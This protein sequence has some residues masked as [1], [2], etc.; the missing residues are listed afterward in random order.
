MKSS[1]K[2]YLFYA[3]L[4]IV[5]GSLLYILVETVRAKNT[6]FE[7]KTL[8]DWM[9]LFIIPLFLAG[10]AI[11]LN[12]SEKNIE[13]QRAEERGNL[14]RE[15][16]IDRQQEAALQSYLDRMTELL[17]KEKLR[18]ARNKEVR[19][20]ARIRTLTVLRGLDGTRKGFVLRFLYEAGL[21]TKERP[22]VDLDRADLRSANMQDVNLQD[23]SL[24]GCNLKNANLLYANL[25]GAILSRSNLSSVNLFGANLQRADLREA[26]LQDADLKVANLESAIIQ[27]V[28]LSR[29]RMLRAN[30]SHVNLQNSDL[31]NADL[32]G[33]NLEGA[34][35]GGATLNH[36]DL[37][38]ADLTNAKVT[39]EQLSTARSLKGAIMP[40][41]TKHE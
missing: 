4:I 10:G 12:R 2:Q 9:Q 20:V 22:I 34:N 39:S 32:K 11:I 28:A 15:I 38:D 23:V 7:T 19:N 18:T 40:D 6:G 14:E 36:V 26:N 29:A 8:W 3:S 5:G 37:K 16:A 35:L 41:G 13:R 1:W 30:L 31:Q 27:M 33:A 24:I 25:N 17:L 21:I